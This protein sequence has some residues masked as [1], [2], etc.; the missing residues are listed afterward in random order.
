MLNKLFLASLLALSS[1]TAVTAAIADTPRAPVPNACLV[2]TEATT[3]VFQVERKSDIKDHPT[4]S[5]TVVSNGAWTYT[6]TRNGKVIRTEAGCLSNAQLAALQSSLASATWK[7]TQA[8]MRCMAE[9]ADYTQ[10]SYKGKA[11][12]C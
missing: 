5:L 6:E 9:A 3:P 12:R 11:R 8:D 2:T 7:T 1:S 10:Y 4:T